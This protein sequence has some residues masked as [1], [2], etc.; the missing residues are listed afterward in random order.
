MRRANRLLMSAICLLLG[1][2]GCPGPGGPNPDGGID[3]GA[4]GSE[5]QVDP[6]AAAACDAKARAVCT[7]LGACLPSRF[8]FLFPDMNTCVTRGALG[9]VH[10]FSYTGTGTKPADT[11]SCASAYDSLACEDLMAGIPPAA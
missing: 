11:Q 8:S 5:G 10:E 9:C 2:F 6:A 4:C 1:G 7:R 3:G